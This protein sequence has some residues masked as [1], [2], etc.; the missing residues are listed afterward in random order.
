MPASPLAG[1]PAPADLLIDP[2]RL[3]AAYYDRHPD[4]ANPR[5]QVAFG[6]SGHR[7]APE[8]SAFNEAHILTITQ[9]ICEYRARAGITGPLFLAADTHAASDAGAEDRAGGAGGGGGRDARLA[10]RG[11]HADARAVARDPHL[12][13]R[14]QGRPRRRHHHHAVAQPA[15]R[16]RLQVQPAPRRPGRQRHHRRD[17]GARQRAPAHAR[18][19]HPHFVLGGP[20]GLDDARARFSDPL[21]RGSGRRD[22]RRGDRARRGQAGRRS[23]GGRQRAVLAA[24]RRALPARP[25]GRQQDGRSALRVHAAR[26]RRQDPHGLLQPLRDGEPASSQGQVRGRLR[27]RHRRRSPRHRHADR[28]HEPEPLPGGRD[29]LPVRA[30]PGVAGGRGHRQDAGVEHAHRSRGRRPRP[31]AARGAGRLQVVRR[32]AARRQLRLRRRGE[33]RRQLPAPRRPR[34]HHRQ[35]RPDPGPAGRRR[36]PRSPAAIRG[37]TTRTCARSS[38][39]R[40]T[41]ASTRRRRLPRRRR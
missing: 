4:P 1:K 14:A 5:E 9:A 17:P 30:S 22:R 28:A 40:T 11:L 26:S 34:P 18:R 10:R 7:G 24:H 20:A 13:R 27:Q 16:R 36:S 32:R 35:G 6:T 8:D 19:G 12:Q 21:R 23:D 41:R 37:C 3:V 38:G 29:R 25:D 39:R 2:D 31:H 15:A 33:R